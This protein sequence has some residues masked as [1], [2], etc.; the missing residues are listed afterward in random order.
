MRKNE[1]KREGN[2]KAKKVVIR[3]GKKGVIRARFLCY[4]F[5][6]LVGFVAV[7]I[8]FFKVV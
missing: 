1:R 8:L 4:N 6:Y 3:A 2:K 7:D 5:L